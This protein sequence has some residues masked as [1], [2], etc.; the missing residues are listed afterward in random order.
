MVKSK[1]KRI[2]RRDCEIRAVSFDG[3]LADLVSF[4]PMLI[5]ATDD[6]T[7]GALC[8]VNTLLNCQNIACRRDAM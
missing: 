8:P 4:C 1:K 5:I 6:S 7:S 3:Q 2:R